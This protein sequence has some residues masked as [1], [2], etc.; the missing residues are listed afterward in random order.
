MIE[1]Y[2]LK[3]FVSTADSFW[4]LPNYVNLQDTGK[5]YL[6]E[7]K[8]I[9]STITGILMIYI[10]CNYVLSIGVRVIQLAYL[11]LIAPIPILFN[12]LP[13]GEDKLKKWG[14][15]AFTTYL[16]L[17]L[18]LIIIYLV[19]FL[20]RFLSAS[21]TELFPIIFEGILINYNMFSDNTLYF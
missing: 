1:Y 4:I 14:K 10:L 12:I 18:R 20:C 6:Y 21:Y 13:N 7:Y 15:Q 8:T 17:F 3:K 9:W 19:L 5:N 16:D 2:D 11:Q